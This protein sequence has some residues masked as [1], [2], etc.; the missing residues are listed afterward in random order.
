MTGRV[1][2]GLIRTPL[3]T[4]SID[5]PSSGTGGPESFSVGKGAFTAIVNRSA[6]PPR[7]WST[8]QVRTFEAM[9]AGQM[10]LSAEADIRVP[11]MPAMRRGSL[12]E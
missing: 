6:V 1:S 4:S 11:A 7:M 2:T 5:N 3:E 12:P 8:A 9:N 10:R